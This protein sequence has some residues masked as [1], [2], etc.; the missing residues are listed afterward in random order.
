MFYGVPRPSNRPQQQ[1]NQLNHIRTT[2][3]KHRRAQTCQTKN[4]HRHRRLRRS[5]PAHAGR[6]ARAGKRGAEAARRA[7]SRAG[8]GPRDLR[9]AVGLDTP[10][11]TREPGPLII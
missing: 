8:T 7:S 4:V 11:A 2:E 9:R 3:A 1:Q 5:S 6:W 10:D